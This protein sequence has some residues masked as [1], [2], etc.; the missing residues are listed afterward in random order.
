MS[1]D[2]KDNDFNED[3]SSSYFSELAK[4]YFKTLIPKNAYRAYKLIM[5][6]LSMSIDFLL[7]HLFFNDKDLWYHYIYKIW[8]NSFLGMVILAYLSKVS[9][10]EQV[11]F[12]SYTLEQLWK[13]FL[14]LITEMKYFIFE[15]YDN[16]IIK[17]YV[18]NK[19]IQTIKNII[20]FSKTYSIKIIY[21]IYNIINY[22]ITKVYFHFKNV[23][24]NMSNFISVIKIQLNSIFIDKKLTKR[25]N[26]I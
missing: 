18:R 4:S 6:Y 8:F 20:G 2:F 13:L 21:F 7:D 24:Y 15:T 5:I 12:F 3:S 1:D 19:L 26:Y 17:I 22:I 11:W 14:I 16:K 23:I 25:S 10:Q 9:I